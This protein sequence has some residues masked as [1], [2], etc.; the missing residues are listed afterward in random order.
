MIISYD[1]IASLCVFG[2]MGRTSNRR[3]HTIAFIRLRSECPS[4]LGLVDFVGHLNRPDEFTHLKISPTGCQPVEGRVIDY[5][6]HA[7]GG[8]IRFEVTAAS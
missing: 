5:L 6:E 1:G 7:T 2:H 8:W 4:G 3:L